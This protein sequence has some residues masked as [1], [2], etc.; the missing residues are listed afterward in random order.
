MDRPAS[1]ASGNS[2]WFK[3]ESEKFSL[4]GSCSPSRALSP[5]STPGTSDG[6][7]D[8]PSSQLFV[9]SAKSA[10]ALQAYIKKYIDFCKQSSSDQ[11]ESI[12]YTSCV[13]REHYRYRFSC[14]ADNLEDLITQLQDALVNKPTATPL[15]NLAFAFP[16]QGSQYQGM[17]RDLAIR[18]PSFLSIVSEASTQAANI[19]GLP[20]LSYLLDTEAP[21]ARSLSESDIAQ[22]CIFVYQYSVGKW[23]QDIGLAPCAV[24]GHSL[25]EI[26]A[27][28][29]FDHC[30]YF[31][32]SLTR[33][34]AVAGSFTFDDA[35][36]FV[37]KRAS[38]LRPDLL[39]PAG[40]AAIGADAD[41]VNGYLDTL[42]MRDR[43][44][45]AVY[46]AESSVVVSGALDAIDTLVFTVKQEGV[47]ATRLDV[48][49]GIHFLRPS[50][51]CTKRSSRAAFHSPYVAPAMPALRK[52]LQD[53]ARSSRPLKI[54]FYSSAH[55]RQI[56]KG[57]SLDAEYWVCAARSLSLIFLS[58]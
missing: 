29:A 9:V 47:K 54:P 6:T 11:F 24:L 33:R 38:V 31:V 51:R 2:S 39:R 25:G 48:N 10:A 14:V 21:Q 55:G 41:T 36:D 53:R 30:I 27:A 8:L 13:G 7:P 19:T 15:R 43:L 57:G 12:C 22:V 18:F 58:C 50:Q 42:S 49:Q 56:S 44:T 3:L 37:I 40:M 5:I 35:L 16:G 1:E 23:L 46:N 45:I 4:S 32:S 20:I 28:G 34:S 17:A 52:W 26:A